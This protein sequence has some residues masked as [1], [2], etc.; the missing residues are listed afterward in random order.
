MR[1]RMN[2]MQAMNLEHIKNP[3][4]L[5]HY[6]A[7]LRAAILAGEIS[8]MNSLHPVHCYNFG[9]RPFQVV[10]WQPKIGQVYALSGHFHTLMNFSP[11][12]R[13]L[14]QFSFYFAEIT[15]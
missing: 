3:Q 10:L 13:F 2:A 8:Q 15:I 11:V 14:Q 1:I 12:I 6:S 4:C 7:R 5:R 9:R